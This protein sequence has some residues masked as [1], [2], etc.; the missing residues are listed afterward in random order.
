MHK[1]TGFFPDSSHAE[2]QR[3]EVRLARPY[4][5]E[6]LEKG[7]GFMADKERTLRAAFFRMRRLRRLQR[8][9]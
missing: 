1:E 9:A 2:G 4:R 5:T 8:S 6:T 3:D 7:D